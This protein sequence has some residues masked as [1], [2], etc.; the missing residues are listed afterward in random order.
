MNKEAMKL[1]DTLS[2]RGCK[3]QEAISKI[4]LRE[5]VD[6]KLSVA[7]IRVLL[8]VQKALKENKLLDLLMREEEK[9]AE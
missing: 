9:N 6:L 8:D 2:N 3:T 5:V 7:Q 1:L 4:T